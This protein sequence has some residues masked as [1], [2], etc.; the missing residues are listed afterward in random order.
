MRTPYSG[1]G[2]VL[3]STIDCVRDLLFSRDHFGF[4]KSV[5]YTKTTNSNR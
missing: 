1:S 3:A 4:K 5:M 2:G